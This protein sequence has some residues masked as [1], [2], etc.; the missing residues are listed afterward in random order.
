MINWGPKI[1]TGNCPTAQL[2]DMSKELFERENVATNHPDVT[3]KLARILQTE[4]EK[5]FTPKH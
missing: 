5:G 4:R 3:D 2:F 1:E